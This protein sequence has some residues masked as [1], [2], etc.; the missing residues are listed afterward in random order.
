MSHTGL[1]D[2][3][4][5]RTKSIQWERPFLFFGAYFLSHLSWLVIYPFVRWL[6]NMRDTTWGAWVMPPQTWLLILCTSLLIALLAPIVF[7][8]IPNVTFAVLVV[9]VFSALLST[10][11]QFAIYSINDDEKFRAQV[12]P[13]FWSPKLLLFKAL[14]IGCFLGGMALALRR[15]KPVWLALWLGA[16]AGYLVT[17]LVNEIINWPISID[18]LTNALKAQLIFSILEKAIF[19]MAFWAGLRLTA[20][21]DLSAELKETR[22]MKGFYLGTMITAI[23]VPLVALALVLASMVSTNWWSPWYMSSL[24]LLI[25]L[26]SLIALFGQVVIL[27]LTY[28]MWG[29]IQDGH[30]RT[31]PGAA[32]GLLFVPFFNLYW[33]FQAYR[34]FA[35][36]FNSFCARHSINPPLLPTSLFTAYGVLMICGVIPFIGWLLIVVN[37]FVALAMISKI[38]DA[39]NSIPEKLP[40]QVA[41][42]TAFQA[43]YR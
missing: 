18:D 25:V 40:D 27:V 17:W 39:V 37:F 26:V 4:G 3:L 19:A 8:F 16:T 11:I 29:A 36:D 15:I 41:G 32:V 21:K 13:T 38:C 24:I 5:V 34:G 33:I 10:L 6:F 31:T 42:G 14:E 35:E 9:S 7:R 20:G 23:C 22:L 30:A 12:L 43:L 28:R 1:A 2:L